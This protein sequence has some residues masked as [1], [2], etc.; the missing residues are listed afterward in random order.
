MDMQALIDAL[1]RT[2]V[3]VFGNSGGYGGMRP[4]DP[5]LMQQPAMA[6][7]RVGYKDGGLE[8]GVSG[9]VMRLPDGRVVRQMGP[10]DVGYSVPMMGGRAGV[11]AG[12]G[13]KGDY[14]AQLMYQREF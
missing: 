11:K 7:G 1:R 12:V 8:A 4:G 13:P 2:D 9:S 10:V 14:K 6:G 3:K 5:L